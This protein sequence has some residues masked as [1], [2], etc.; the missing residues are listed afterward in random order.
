[1][2]KKKLHIA[3]IF[4][5][6]SGEHD[7]SLMSAR[8][9]LTVL[10]PV[11]YEVTQIGITLAGQWL[12]GEDVIGKFE[13]GRTKELKAA[14]VSPDP[15][16]RGVYVLHNTNYVKLTDIAIAFAAFARCVCSFSYHN[17]SHP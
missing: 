4:G 13:T 5:G 12:T 11:K 2:T 6:R 15:S 10:D 8:N 14:L 9:V 3:V 17:T 16:M 7:V 1:M